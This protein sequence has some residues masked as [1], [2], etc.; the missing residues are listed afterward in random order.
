MRSNERGPADEDDVISNGS[1]QRC[2]HVADEMIS[3]G[4]LSADLEGRLHLGC[5]DLHKTPGTG[6]S[7]RD[8]S[9]RL[10]VKGLFEL[11]YSGVSSIFGNERTEPDQSAVESSQLLHALP[12]VWCRVSGARGGRRRSAP[13][14]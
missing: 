13:A 4:L 11:A 14:S 8:R 6:M 2:A 10:P 12:A 1:C 3:L 9:P 7:A 5:V